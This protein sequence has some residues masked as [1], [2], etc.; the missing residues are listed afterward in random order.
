MAAGAGQRPPKPRPHRSEGGNNVY[1][2]W[3]RTVSAT[4][5]A[6]LARGTARA[7]SPAGFFSP[8]KNQLSSL[9]RDPAKGFV[10]VLH[11][12]VRG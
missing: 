7:T 1:Y 12:L 10:A 9:S 6:P 4:G 3:L 2:A 5:V 8:S 11:M